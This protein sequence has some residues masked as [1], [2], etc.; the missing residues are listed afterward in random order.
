MSL[1]LLIL[2]IRISGCASLKEK[3]GRIKPLLARLGREFNVSAAELDY[4]DNWQNALIGCS[5]LSNNHHHTQR[6][7]QKIIP[8]IEKHRPDLYIIEEK[9]EYF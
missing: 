8:W 7:L 3:R 4:Q 6:S 5:L 1:G 9:I 2:H